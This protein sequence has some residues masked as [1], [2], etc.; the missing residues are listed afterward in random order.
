MTDAEMRKVKKK[1]KTKSKN[2]ETEFHSTKVQ[3]SK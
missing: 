3:M 2:C 1:V